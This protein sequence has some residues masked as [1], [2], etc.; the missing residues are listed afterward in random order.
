MPVEKQARVAAAAKGAISKA[1]TPIDRHVG[2][3]LWECR[4]LAGLSQQQL[5]YRLGVTFQQIQKY[6]KGV[7]RISASQLYQISR[8]FG[9][10]IFW[11]FEGWAGGGEHEP[12]EN[13]STA[14]MA[15]DDPETGR[16]VEVVA[17]ITDPRKRRRLREI[18]AI[19]ADKPASE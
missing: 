1:V 8:L 12:A 11:F 17:R 18:M 7:N 3:R 16:F 5:A 4:R 2:H 14:S 10:S 15:P 13:L 6:E 9:V 19:L